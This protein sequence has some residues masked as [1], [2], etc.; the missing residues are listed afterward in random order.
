MLANLYSSPTDILQLSCTTAF[1]QHS[2]SSPLD[3]LRITALVKLL[4]PNGPLYV[5]FLIQNS[6]LALE[7][8]SNHLMADI[9]QICWVSSF[10]TPQYCNSTLLIARVTDFCTTWSSLSDSDLN[11]PLPDFIDQM[12]RSPCG[13]ARPL[14]RHNRDQVVYVFVLQAFALGSSHLTFGW[15]DHPASS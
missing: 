7:V 1:A 8:Y 5:P 3:A 11:M 13:G 9:S 10:D 15:T 4:S 6:F 2:S 12:L 14:H